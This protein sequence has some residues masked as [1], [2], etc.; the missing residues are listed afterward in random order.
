MVSI[1]IGILW[2]TSVLFFKVG[3]KRRKWKACAFV[4]VCPN[5][6]WERRC[7]CLYKA[8]LVPREL[9]PAPLS[10]CWNPCW[11]R[12]GFQQWWLME[13]SQC[14]SSLETLKQRS[15]PDVVCVLR[16]QR[17]QLDL[18][19][20]RDR[21]D[22]RIQTLSTLLVWFPSPATSAHTRIMSLSSLFYPWGD[23]A[24]RW[25]MLPAPR[26]WQSG[27]IPKKRS[28]LSFL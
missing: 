16:L 2:L 14:Q 22:R 28:C 7:R 6:W 24:A 20:R 11:V 19:P 8:P 9:L 10:A 13:Q 27:E 23:W 5:G 4:F 1:K 21:Q 12:S 25:A 15:L 3:N 26:T 18:P 17:K